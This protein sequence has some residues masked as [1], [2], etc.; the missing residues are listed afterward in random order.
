MA[1]IRLR[2]T[3]EKNVCHTQDNSIGLSIDSDGTERDF[4]FRNY[5]KFWK[6]QS[7]KGAN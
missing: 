7:S 6:D 5:H 4:L 2:A 3:V 1:T